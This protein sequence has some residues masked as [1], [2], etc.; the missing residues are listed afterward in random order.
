MIYSYNSMM[1]YKYSNGQVKYLEY[2]V[3]NYDLQIGMGRQ[4]AIQW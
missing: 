2:Y 4:S 1:T 3:H